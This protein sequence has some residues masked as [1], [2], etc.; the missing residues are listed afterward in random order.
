[1]KP[2]QPASSFSVF[3]EKKIAG[4]IRRKIQSR[5]PFHLQITSEPPS[6]LSLPS[7]SL[8]PVLFPF[9]PTVEPP[10]SIDAPQPGL[11]AECNLYGCLLAVVDGSFRFLS[12]N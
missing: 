10:L 1:M 8:F 12:G 5:L 11:D 3:A 9:Y 4:S 6:C 7:A 2:R